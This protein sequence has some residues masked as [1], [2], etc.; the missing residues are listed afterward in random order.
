M[1]RSNGELHCWLKHVIALLLVL[2]PIVEAK[3]QKKELTNSVL[4]LQVCCAIWVI[5]IFCRLK[6]F[7]FQNTT[8]RFLP[9]FFFFLW[10]R[11]D[12]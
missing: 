3:N 11:I 9:F 5:S 6:I 7:F 12:E 4:C 10:Q 2:L 8:F 1:R